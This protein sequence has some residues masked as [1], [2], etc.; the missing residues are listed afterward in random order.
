MLSVYLPILNYRVSII[1][2]LSSQF[3]M[4][5]RYQPNL[6]TGTINISLYDGTINQVTLPWLCISLVVF[7]IYHNMQ[8]A[9]IPQVS[10][11]DQL[12]RNILSHYYDSDYR[13]SSCCHIQLYLLDIFRLITTNPQ[14][15]FP[16]TGIPISQT[17]A[18]SW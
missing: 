8:C 11:L 6:T 1:R 3:L 12:L 13:Q 10:Y 4:K 7:V 9:L 2:G 14:T 18:L 5:T 15:I 17:T 16:T